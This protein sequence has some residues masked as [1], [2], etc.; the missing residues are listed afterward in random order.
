MELNLRRKKPKTKTSLVWKYVEQ[1]TTLDRKGEEVTKNKCNFCGELFACKGGNTS[2]TRKHLFGLHFEQMDK[3]DIPGLAEENPDGQGPSEGHFFRETILLPM[4]Y[5]V[6]NAIYD[7]IYDAWLTYIN[8]MHVLD[9]DSDY[10]IEN[11][12]HGLIQKP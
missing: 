11:D 6:L 9:A 4:L 5:S 3:N 2:T 10:E 12:T 7:T 1:I 8:Y